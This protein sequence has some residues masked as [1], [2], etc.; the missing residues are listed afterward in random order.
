MDDFYYY[1]FKIDMT[2]KGIINFVMNHY[3]FMPNYKY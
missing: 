1:Y 2:F 3:E